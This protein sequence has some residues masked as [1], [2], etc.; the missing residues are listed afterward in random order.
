MF[1]HNT[2]LTSSTL[3]ETVYYGYDN[4]FKKQ[5]DLIGQ[6]LKTFVMN[7]K[8]QWMSLWM[9]NHEYAKVMME[10]EIH[11]GEM[12]IGRNTEKT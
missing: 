6:I 9:A 2:I 1:S 7:T 10:L 8:M 4:P 11:S 12:Y 3:G 5:N